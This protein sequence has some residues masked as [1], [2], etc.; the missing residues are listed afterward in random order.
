MIAS[1]LPSP[2]H[3]ASKHL[4]GDVVGDRVV[5][6]ALDQAGELLCRDRR[7]IGESR[8]SLVQPR[9]EFAHDPVGDGLGVGGAGGG[10][11]RSK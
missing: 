2:F 7:A 10:H 3:S 11:R 6:D 1:A 4:L 5:G 8:S 9:R